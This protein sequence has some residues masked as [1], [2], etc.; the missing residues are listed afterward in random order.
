VLNSDI[1]VDRLR[2]AVGSERVIVDPDIMNS[3]RA[4]RTTTV[5]GE[6]PRVVITPSSTAQIARAV[7]LANEFEVPVI[8]QGAL[9]GL[10]G[11][12][13]PISG[14]LVI[15]VA[16]MDRILDIDPVNLLATVEPGVINKTLKDAV[17]KEGFFYPPDPGSYTFCSIG[18]NVSTNAGG[19]CCV[20]YGVTA[21][22]VSELEIVSPAG[23]IM[24]L[25]RRTKKSSAGYRL[26]QLF[27]GS[28]GTL[29]VLTKATMRL[30]HAP[31]PVA[32][33]VVASFSI[34]E[35][36]G[37][38]LREIA[39]KLSP[40]LL[41]VMDQE[42]VRAINAWKNL[43]IDEEAEAVI[44]AQ[45]DV[46][47]G[48]GAEELKLIE[49]ICAQSGSGEIYR[50]E[51]PDE[52]DALLEA[53][54]L[55]L[56][57]LERLG[58]AILDDVGVPVSR[59]GEMISEIAKIAKKWQITVGTFGHGGDGNLHPTL[60]LP[61]RDQEV[62]EIADRCFADI[63]AAA[64]SMGGTISGEHGIGLIKRDFMK[65]QYGTEEIEWM[66]LIKAA[67]DPKWLFNPNKVVFDRLMP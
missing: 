42:T 35:E 67:L 29:G 49:A 19:L 37:D 20:K 27:V 17:A 21:D 16:K 51:D 38:A 65:D 1:F 66:R 30:R 26:A 31:A 45:S 24:T 63:V 48:E 11:G 33:T 53:R 54:R 6:M 2:D 60:V 62:I 4:D 39:S 52:A 41:E 58:P 28:E 36:M 7:K 57:A 44:V 40:S 23:E 64:L 32:G 10:A 9:S 25:G 8:P 61:S 50:T 15:N 56:T 14:S 12:A 47:G 55:A 59:I 5:Q 34:L 13:D 3:Y 22:Y 46:K 43:G 18:G